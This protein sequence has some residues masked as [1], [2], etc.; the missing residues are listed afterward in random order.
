MAGPRAAA[1]TKK[2]A[3]RNGAKWNLGDLLHDP[4]RDLDLLRKEMDGQVRRFEEFRERLSPDIPPD[5]FLEALRLADAIAR[6]T[7]KLGAYA[8]L[9]FSENTDRKSTRLNSSHIQKSRMPS[10]A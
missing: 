1:K 7:S 9:W 4:T 2:R 10:S 5:T 6:T 8:Y 3:A